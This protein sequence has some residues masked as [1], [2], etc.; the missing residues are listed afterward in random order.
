[1]SVWDIAEHADRHIAPYPNARYCRSNAR[2][3]PPH[4]APSSSPAAERPL[5]SAGE[6]RGAGMKGVW[7]KIKRGIS[8]K[9]KGGWSEDKR[10]L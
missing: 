5:F 8:M 2:Y 10:G 1:M 7:G 6:R 3:R 9:T 4:A